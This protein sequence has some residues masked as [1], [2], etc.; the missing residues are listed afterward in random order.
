[1]YFQF[2][3]TLY[4]CVHHPCFSLSLMENSF[5]NSGRSRIT[6]MESEVERRH[7]QQQQQQQQLDVE[8]GHSVSGSGSVTV[9][10]VPGEVC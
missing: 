3:P 9:P 7:L 10:H 6:G 4:A 2:G 5:L 8:I 1:M